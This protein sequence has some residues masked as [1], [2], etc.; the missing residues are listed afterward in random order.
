MV[1]AQTWRRPREFVRGGCGGWQVP[2]GRVA[3]RGA[4]KWKIVTSVLPLL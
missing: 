3:T 2:D 4:R 1:T